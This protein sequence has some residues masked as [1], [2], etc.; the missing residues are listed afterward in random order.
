M[1]TGTARTK[2]PV[3]I[4]WCPT[5][6][7]ARWPWSTHSRAR[8]ATI[9]APTRWVLGKT[10]RPGCTPRACCPPKAGLTNSEHAA[11]LR[12]REAL[13][14]VLAA[15]AD[16]R[17]DAAA[18][19]RL[20]RAL[21]EG[22]LVVIVDTASTVRLASAARAS[23]PAWWRPSPSPSPTRPRPARGPDSQADRSRT[24]LR[25]LGPAV[26]VEV[27]EHGGQ[28]HAEH[29]A[30][31]VAKQLR[32]EGPADAGEAGVVVGEAGARRRGVR[33]GRRPPSCRRPGRRSTSSAA[34][35][36]RSP[37]APR[38]RRRRSSRAWACATS[39]NFVPTTVANPSVR[40]PAPV[41]V[42]SGTRAGSVTARQTFAGG[43]G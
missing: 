28:A 20:T 42:H 29:L 10:R 33:A 30:A 9:P 17:K 37:P 21:A 25:S 43:W 5:L 36:A 18:A 34:A 7:M 40:P 22:R 32:H 16:G 12:T 31:D 27:I 24:F 3:T 6:P 8:S 35:T 23:Y 13:R 4:R 19:E 15:H 11:L 41:A 26:L 39:R 14:D 1:F 2:G 38:S